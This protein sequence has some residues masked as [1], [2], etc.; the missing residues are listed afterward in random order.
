[1]E[2]ARNIS[3]EYGAL[4]EWYWHI[5]VEAPEETN[6]YHTKY[7]FDLNKFKMD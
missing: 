6:V 2:A 7:R 1:M 5:F 3:M 4:V